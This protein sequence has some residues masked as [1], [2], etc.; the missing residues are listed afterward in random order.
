MGLKSPIVMRAAPK[1][2][3]YC[4]DQVYVSNKRQIIRSFARYSHVRKPPEYIDDLMEDPKGFGWH[5][6]G[7]REIKETPWK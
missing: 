5:S 2:D 4:R 6:W 1:S 3:R 7:L